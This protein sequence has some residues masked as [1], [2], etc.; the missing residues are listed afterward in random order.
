M[1][2]PDDDFMR[3]DIWAALLLTGSALDP[4]QVTA[5]AGMQPT[6]AWRRGDLIS[7]RTPRRHE[8]GGWRLKSRLPVS[9]DLAAHIDDVLDQLRPHWQQFVELGKRFDTTLECV[10]ET[11]AYDRPAIAL[12]KEV[13]KLLSEL[14]AE[15]DVDLYAFSADDA[16]RRMSASPSN[17]RRSDRPLR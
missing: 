12:K 15:F 13:I 1:T 9:A 7:N 16:R 17:L 3:S 6:K 4:E 10:V 2:T 14:D 11:F 8:K 5:D